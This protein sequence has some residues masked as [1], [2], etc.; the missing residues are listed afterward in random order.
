MKKGFRI[1]ICVAVC[2]ALM[3]ALPLQTYASEDNSITSVS[4]QPDT[5]TVT[6]SGTCAETVVAVVIQIRDSKN[7]ILTMESHQAANGS[8]MAVVDIS[9]QP[10]TYKAYVANYDGGSWNST[11]FSVKQSG[12]LTGGTTVPSVPADNTITNSGSEAAGNSST[13]VNVSD[14][15][16]VSDGKTETTVDSD[17]GNKIVENAVEKKSTEV[18]IKA[19]TAKGDSTGASVTLPAET[20][21]AISEKT[22]ATV[23]IE[24]DSASISLDQDALAAV[25]AQSGATGEVKLVVEIREQNKNKVEI[26]LKII[27]D[28]GTVSD[29]NGGNVTVSVPV[30]QELAKKK[31]VCVYIDDNGHMSKVKGQMNADGTFTFTTGHFSTYA[32]LAE[33]DA[34]AAIAEQKEAIWNIDVK[35]SSKQVKTKTGKKGIKITWTADAGDK[36]L[37]G[38]EVF[39]STCRSKGYGTKPFYISTKGGNE[40]YYINTKSLKTGTRYYYR[41][42]G[43]IL[44]NG[45]KVYTD[46]SNKAWRTVK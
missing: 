3:F 5:N 20:V 29:F 44:V 17:L 9:L 15:T 39:R 40:G 19:E 25:A 24:T 37:D 31:V 11:E 43:Y 28:K 34:D 4:V 10:G 16:T 46:Y 13:N 45:Q 41:V 22:E 7:S 35:L 32:I 23:T 18:V 12:G 38:V 27:T 6:V 36:T 2:M 8:Y 14:K 30:D 21:Q 42:R 33:E 1:F 26:D